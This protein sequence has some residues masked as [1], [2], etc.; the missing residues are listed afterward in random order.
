M[1]QAML[2]EHVAT[3][4]NQS[5]GRLA[6]GLLRRSRALSSDY[7]AVLDARSAAVKFAWM[8]CSGVVA[9]I[10]IVTAWLALVAAGI[11]WMLGTGASWI[12]ALGVAALINLVG[13]GAIA[14]C[15]CIMDARTFR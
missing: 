7:L 11:V 15:D 13:A 6:G 3:S 10:L 1:R 14:L 9:A 5:I 8:L 2:G 12:T 4:S